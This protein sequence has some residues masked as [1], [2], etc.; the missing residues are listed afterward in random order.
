MNEATRTKIN[1]SYGRKLHLPIF[2]KNRD[3]QKSKENALQAYKVAT[4][5][6]L[7][8]DRGVRILNVLQSGKGMNS[9][10]TLFINLNDSIKTVRSKAKN[11]FTKIKYDPEEAALENIK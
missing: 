5:Q 2:Y 10:A 3:Y 8:N 4:K 1:D 7:M 11:Q 9:Y 6:V